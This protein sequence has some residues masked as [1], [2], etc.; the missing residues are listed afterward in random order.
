M[1]TCFATLLTFNLVCYVVQCSDSSFLFHQDRR[2]IKL[3]SCGL[4]GKAHFGRWTRKGGFFMNSPAISSPWRN[5]CNCLQKM[6]TNQ[7]PNKST[8][9]FLLLHW[10]SF[11]LWTNTS[12]CAKDWTIGVHLAVCADTVAPILT[13]NANTKL[14]KFY[15]CLASPS[16]ANE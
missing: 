4:A 13:W 9:H 15:F 8:A 6:Y 16:I 14:P 7:Q 3:V 10:L 1:L 12:T 2:K 5:M 11:S